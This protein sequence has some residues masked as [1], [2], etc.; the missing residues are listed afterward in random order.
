[1]SRYRMPQQRRNCYAQTPIL[2]GSTVQPHHPRHVF[3]SGSQ[4]AILYDSCSG[5]VENCPIIPNNESVEV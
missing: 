4:S 5:L 1:M 2:T 3:L